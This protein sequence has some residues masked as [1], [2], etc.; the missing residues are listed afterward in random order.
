MKHET[1]T[2][3]LLLRHTPKRSA[4]SLRNMQAEPMGSACCAFKA[5]G[6]GEEEEHLYNSFCFYAPESERPTDSSSSVLTAT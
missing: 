1:I 5:V 6:C 2:V 4:T 3:D